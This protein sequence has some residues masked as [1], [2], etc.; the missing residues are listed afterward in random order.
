MSDQRDE[1]LH[2]CIAKYLSIGIVVIE[3]VIIDSPLVD[4][5]T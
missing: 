4:P 5:S 2:G 3:A 1:K